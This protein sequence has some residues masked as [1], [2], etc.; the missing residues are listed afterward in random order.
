MG[1][2]QEAG[3]G[4]QLRVQ[5]DPPPREE[6]IR[7]KDRTENKADKRSFSL[8]ETKSE[9]LDKL[10]KILCMLSQREACDFKAKFDQLTMA[11][12]VVWYGFEHSLQS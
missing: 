5:W 12:M 6:V 8:G 1:G 11:W 10:K 9:H 7:D 4:G 3:G 2:E